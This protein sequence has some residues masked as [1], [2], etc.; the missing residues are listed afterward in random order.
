MKTQSAKSSHSILE[1]GQI[2]RVF[3]VKLTTFQRTRL[4]KQLYRTTDLEREFHESTNDANKTA[5]NS[6]I[7]DIRVKV[8]FGLW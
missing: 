4:P 5:E 7:R 6:L 8:F 3:T 1:E 2:S